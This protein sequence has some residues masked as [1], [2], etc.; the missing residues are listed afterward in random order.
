MRRRYSQWAGPGAAGCDRQRAGAVR[1][2]RGRSP[3][4][5]FWFGLERLDGEREWARPAPAGHPGGAGGRRHR[6]GPRGAG[7]WRCRCCGTTGWSSGD[8]RDS[9]HDPT[10]NPR[11][12]LYSARVA[13][14][15]SSAWLECRTVTAEVAGSSPVSPAPVFEAAPRPGGRGVVVSNLSR[16]RWPSR[17]RPTTSPCSSSRSSRLRRALARAVDA[18]LGGGG[19][20]E[21]LRRAGLEASRHRPGSRRDRLRPGAPGR[22]GHP[23]PRGGLRFARGARRGRRLPPGVHS[24][25]SGRVLPP[26][27]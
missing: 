2:H 17:T 16:P 4:G 15:C 9:W 13:G 3:A 1:R 23:V 25:G 19:H 24:A 7:S 8:C 10:T 11:L 22:P 5:G 6:G 21:A 20:A 18:T 14:G 12:P 27:G 26:I